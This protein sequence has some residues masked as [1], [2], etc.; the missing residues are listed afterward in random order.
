MSENIHVRSI[1]GRFLEHSRI[2]SFEADERVATY[3]GSPDLMQR[4]LDHR[5]EVLVPVENARARA[6]VHAILDSALAD[7][8]NAW[9]LAPSGEW[10]RVTPAKPDRLHSHHETM[11]RRS[12]K[13]ARRGARDRRAG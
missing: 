9:I 8:A 4:N 6:E 2:Y 12:L 13:R 1:V 11:M 7:D 3:I 5:I 10:A